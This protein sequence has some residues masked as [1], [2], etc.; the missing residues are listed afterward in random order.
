MLPHTPPLNQFSLRVVRTTKEKPTTKSP[1]TKAVISWVLFKYPVSAPK[2]KK[3]KAERTTQN[4]SVLPHFD[5]EWRRDD[6]RTKHK[7][8][9]KETNRVG[10]FRNR[11]PVFFPRL[12]QS[13]RIRLTRRR[14]NGR[15]YPTPHKGAKKLQI[16]APTIVFSLFSQKRILY[17]RLIPTAPFSF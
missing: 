5:S 9:K 4:P 7:N 13:E 2:K 15:T 12:L 6:K 11:F 8:R 14:R 1:F 10:F 16:K 3:R 17:N